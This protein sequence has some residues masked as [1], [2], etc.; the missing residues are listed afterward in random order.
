M[1]DTDNSWSVFVTHSICLLLL[2]LNGYKVKT[3]RQK[4]CA[5]HR[6]NPADWMFVLMRLRGHVDLL[7]VTRLHMISVHRAE[8]SKPELWSAACLFS[9]LQ[10]SH[11]YERCT[12][13]RLTDQK[14]TFISSKD[15]HHVH[16]VSWILC[17]SV[18]QLWENV[19][20]VASVRTALPLVAGFYMTRHLSFALSSDVIY[21]RSPVF[22]SL[23]PL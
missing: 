4:K 18:K 15:W 11:A 1:T 22:F 2:L 23:Y 7:S 10:G 16:S 9:R 17:S 19:L 3:L 5:P 8:F 12:V 20:I 6:C 13:S 21:S 14:Y